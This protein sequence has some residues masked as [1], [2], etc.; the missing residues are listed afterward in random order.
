MS[1]CRKVEANFADSYDGFSS[2]TSLF[3]RDNLHL[4]RLRVGR[5]CSV[6]DKK[7]RKVTRK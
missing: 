2:G 4:N 6:L 5:L 1:T 3:A 7:I